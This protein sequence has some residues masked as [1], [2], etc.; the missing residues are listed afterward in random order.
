MKD[1]TWKYYIPSID[2]V[3]YWLDYPLPFIMINNL[4]FAL[5]TNGVDGFCIAGDLVLTSIICLWYAYLF[6]LSV[7]ICVDNS[8]S[9][10]PCSSFWR[11][12]DL[13]PI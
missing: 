3:G 12:F 5:H 6:L 9:Q 2:A 1:K 7:L 4:I 13:I 8:P 11:D 10:T